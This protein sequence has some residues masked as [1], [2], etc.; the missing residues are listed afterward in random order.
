V[1]AVIVVFN[2]PPFIAE[3]IRSALTQSDVDVEVI[4]V[5]DASSDDTPAV[6]A[7]FGDLITVLRNEV[8]T[9]RGA[10]HNRGA[11]AGRGSASRSS[12]AT[13]AGC[14]GSSSRR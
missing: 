7:S 4:V 13:I 10:A 11:R 6:L 14:R 8:E 2:Q 3:A 12:T 5:D 9:E 1:S